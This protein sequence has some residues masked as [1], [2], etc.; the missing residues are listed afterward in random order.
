MA[1]MAA[2][3]WQSQPNATAEQVKTAIEMSGHLY[4]NPNDKMGFGIP[5]MYRAWQLAG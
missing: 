2:C 3:L 1:G 4:E 5:D